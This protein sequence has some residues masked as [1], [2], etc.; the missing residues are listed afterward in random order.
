VQSARRC[1]TPLERCRERKLDG[2]RVE[3]YRH[4]TA[5]PETVPRRDQG[6]DD[7]D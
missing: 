2:D 7:D 3:I 5:D 6:P 1:A 4:I